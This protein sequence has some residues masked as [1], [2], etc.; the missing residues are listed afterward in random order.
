MRMLVSFNALPKNVIHIKISPIIVQGC[1]S[2]ECSKEGFS[3]VCV[4]LRVSAVRLGPSGRAILCDCLVLRTVQ[5]SLLCNNV[6][7]MVVL[8]HICGPCIISI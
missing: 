7:N 8:N 3:Y 6:N 2:L 1:V 5:C 4:R